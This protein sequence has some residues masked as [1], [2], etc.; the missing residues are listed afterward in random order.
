MMGIPCLP[1]RGWG[2]PHRGRSVAGWKSQC[3]G[4]NGAWPSPSSSWARLPLRPEHRTQ[5]TLRSVLYRRCGIR[6]QLESKDGV[7][8]RRIWMP[9]R[10]PFRLVYISSP[11]T[12]SSLW[13]LAV[14]GAQG[15]TVDTLSRWH[16]FRA[17]VASNKT[18]API[19]WYTEPPCSPPGKL[20]GA[21]EVAPRDPAH[22]A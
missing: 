17:S 1:S 15:A 12:L 8:N 11:A 4:I 22:P 10:L 13:L 21:H 20:E 5:P 7:P 9:D 18:C 6:H 2:A 19:R 3:P 14:L 16:D